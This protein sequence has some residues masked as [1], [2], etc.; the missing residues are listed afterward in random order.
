MPTFDVSVIGE[1]NLDLILYGLPTELVLEQ[2][3]LA[4]DLSITLLAN[5]CESGRCWTPWFRFLGD[6]LRTRF[7]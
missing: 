3:H 2:E 1:L 5:L 7:R 6:S 4:K